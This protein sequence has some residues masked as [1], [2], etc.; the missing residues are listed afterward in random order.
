MRFRTA[1]NTSNFRRNTDK[2]GRLATLEE[3]S[4]RRGTKS[5]GIRLNFSRGS[6]KGLE[7]KTSVYWWCAIDP[8][9]WVGVHMYSAA[10][11][12]RL[13]K[14]YQHAR[15]SKILSCEHTQSASLSTAVSCNDCQCCFQLPRLPRLSLSNVVCDCSLAMAVHGS[16]RVRMKEWER[17]RIVLYWLTLKVHSEPISTVKWKWNSWLW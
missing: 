14:W 10:R 17:R 11:S 12:L 2:Y 16:E 5:S 9:P 13:A 15:R 4:D 7:Q 1:E 8:W 6:G 3:H